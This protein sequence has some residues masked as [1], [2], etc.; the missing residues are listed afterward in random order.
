VAGT[1]DS[2]SG[3]IKL[4]VDG[5]LENSLV[6]AAAG[7]RAPANLRIGSIRTGVAAGFLAGSIDDARIYNYV[8]SPPEIV[9]LLNTRPVLAA[10][11]NRSI[12]AGAV[13]AITNS[14]SD[15]DLPAQ[16]LAYS[17]NGP[18]GASINPSNGIFVWRPTMAQSA[19]TNLFNVVVSDNG[20]PSLSATQGFSV[21]VN[22]PVQPGLTGGLSNGQIRLSISGDSGPDYTVQASSNLLVW[23]SIFTTNQPALPFLFVDPGMTNADQRFYRVLLGP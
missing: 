15:S 22:R 18:A 17:L 9:A 8:L 4:Y 2:A 16:T 10:I 5:V 3:E 12:I 1:R 13:L 11:S 23:S 6:T 20:T 19:T 7:T 14:A 21:V